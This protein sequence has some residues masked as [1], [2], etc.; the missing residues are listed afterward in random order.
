MKSK[1]TTRGRSRP[2]P[3]AR[4]SMPLPSTQQ[5]APWISDPDPPVK[6]MSKAESVRAAGAAKKAMQERGLLPSSPPNPKSRSTQ[7]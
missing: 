3:S 6:P 5:Y 7:H 1:S 4:G 2:S